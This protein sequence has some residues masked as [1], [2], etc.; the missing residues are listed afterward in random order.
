MSMRGHAMLVLCAALSCGAQSDGAER[1]RVEIDAHG[2]GDATMMQ[3]DDMRAREAEAR[4]GLARDLSDALV[5]I[6]AVLLH[7]SDSAKNAALERLGSMAI[8]TGEAGREQARMFRS[9]VVAGGA[10]P[11]LVSLLTSPE[12]ERQFLAAKAIHALALDD[13]TTDLD[14]F[15]SLEICQGGAISPLVELLASE[16]E[17]VQGAATGALSVLA[18]NPTCQQMIV[19]A[20]AVEPLMRMTTFANDWQKLGALGALD[21][22]EIN[23]PTART[24]L[25]ALNAQTVLKGLTSMGSALL[26]EQAGGFQQRLG[27]PAPATQMSADEQVQSARQTRMKYDG[28]RHKAMRLMQGWERGNGGRGRGRGA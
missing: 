26:R 16:N 4:A 12:Y 18:E 10:V 9:A 21:V 3:T 25:D 28:V 5:D 7:G 23:N 6:M 17:A 14:N 19:A 11:E 15:H 22:L 27:Q 24:Q 13:P 1:L 8:S 2:G 20:G